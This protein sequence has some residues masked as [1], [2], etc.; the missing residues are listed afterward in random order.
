M[1]QGYTGDLTSVAAQVFVESLV[2]GGNAAED[3]SIQVGLQCWRPAES[4][5][6]NKLWLL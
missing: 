4:L 6:T 2:E 5:V 3:G 1:D